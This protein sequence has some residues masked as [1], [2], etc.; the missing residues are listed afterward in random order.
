M[1]VPT[2]PPP[3]PSPR[4]FRADDWWVKTPA[5]EASADEGEGASAE[6]ASAPPAARGKRRMVFD[7]AT[8]E[9]TQDTGDVVDAAEAKR[10]RRRCDAAVRWVHRRG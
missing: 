5:G 3:P 1:V 2:A 9:F 7:G 8:A 4:P 6:E 10:A